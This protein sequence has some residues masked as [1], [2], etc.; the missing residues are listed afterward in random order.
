MTLER[1]VSVL[2]RV[3]STLHGQRFAHEDGYMPGRVVELPQEKWEDMGRPEQIT[4]VVYPGDAMND[5]D[6]PAFTKL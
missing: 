3:S 4:V 6:H 1:S 5:I 2:E